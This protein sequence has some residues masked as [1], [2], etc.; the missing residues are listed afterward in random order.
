[1]VKN[2]IV[3]L[4]SSKTP[5][6]VPV[7]FASHAKSMGADGEH[8]NSISELEEAFKR[9]KK[10]KKTYVISQFIQMDING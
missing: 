8:V 10:S 9:A 3:Y 4:K 2:L 5:N 7:D 1:M 6:L